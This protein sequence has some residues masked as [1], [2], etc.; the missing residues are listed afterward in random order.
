MCLRDHAHT[1][2]EVLRP[3]GHEWVEDE[4]QYKA[5]TCGEAGEKV[6][7]C[8]N[9]NLAGEQCTATYKEAVEPTGDHQYSDEITTAATCGADGVMTHTC[10]V[11]GYSYTTVIPATGDHTYNEEITKEATCTQAG[12][13][14]HKCKVCG[15][16]YDTVIPKTAHQYIE[17]EAQYVAP[18][19]TETGKRVYVCVNSANGVDCGH[20]YTQVLA[21]TGH[22]W[23]KSVE[24]PATCTANGYTTYYCTNHGCDASY[25][26]DATPKIAHVLSV[27]E[28]KDATCGANGYVKYVCANCEYTETTTLDA[29]GDHKYDEQYALKKVVDK[30]GKEVIDEKTGEVKTVQDKATCG[31]VGH[32]DHICETCGY[33]YTTEIPALSHNYTNVETPATCTTTGKIVSTCTNC[34]DVQTYIIPATGHIYD[35]KGVYTPPTCVEDGYTTYTCVV[36]KKESVTKTEGKAAGHVFK[37]NVTDLASVNKDGTISTECIHCGLKSTKSIPA[38][39]SIKLSTTKYV[40][41]GKACRPAV[42]VKDSTGAVISSGNYTLSYS[43]NKKIGTAKVTITFKGDY[44]GTVVKTFKIVPKNVGI[45]DISSP[46]KKVIRFTWG[47]VAKCDGYQ[48]Q[49]STSKTFKSKKTVNIKSRKTCVKKLTGLKS[50]KKYY[51]RVRAYKVV[52]GK[53]IYGNWSTATKIC[54]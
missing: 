32:M 44:T 14:T 28:Q 7:V 41:N 11:C 10:K 33:T 53:K 18:T 43:S 36:C 5:P 24:T 40:Y 20:T 26:S 4:A 27:A 51:I 38:I 48:I 49:Y 25:K 45:S 35:T 9:T 3:T 17:D 21:A 46:S 16:T 30:D 42:T 39:T 22:S 2:T 52:D 31:E 1:Y 6:F 15:Y 47:K 29:T 54:K 37:A 50:G 34:G 12:V 19:C 13:L 23:G 8:K